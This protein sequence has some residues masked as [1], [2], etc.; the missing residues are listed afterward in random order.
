MAYVNVGVRDI[1]G[2]DIRTKA[3]LR[4]MITEDPSSVVIYQTAIGRE[5][6]WPI[7]TYVADVNESDK[8]Q[9]VGPNPY[10]SRKWYAAITFN[11][12]TQKWVVS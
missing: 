9:V 11:A 1:A 2:Q 10:N 3:E 5:H 7:R 6:D 12:R 8:Y 4:R